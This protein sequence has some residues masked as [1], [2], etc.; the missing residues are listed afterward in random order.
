MNLKYHIVDEK[1]IAPFVPELR[2]L[3]EQIEY[4]LDDG[5]G[6]FT[7]DH[8]DAYY[9]FFLQQGIKVRFLIITNNN[10]VVGS[11][12]GV[13]KNITFGERDYMGLYAADLK[14]NP[15][16][17]K[18]GIHRKALWHLFI[19]WPLVKD[20]QGWD[21]IYYCAMQRGGQGV[22]TAFKGLHLGKVANAVA[23]MNIYIVDPEKFSKLNFD[24]FPNQVFKQI[25]LSPHR[26]EELLWNDGVKN[27]IS[28]K[29][30]S[31]LPL[32][33]LHTNLLTRMG[34]KSLK[35]AL[36]KIVN[37]TNGLA[38]FAIDRRDEKRILWL[39]DH[40]IQTN[41]RCKIFSFSPFAPNLRKS[42]ILCISTG[43]I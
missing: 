36:E 31:I 40:G 16:F 35:K 3:E 37:R 13:W 27:I 1:G 41:T 6:G 14:L 29:D 43:E 22:N 26:H 18:K 19:R 38:C 15:D 28:T 10:T 24:N 5:S 8:G 39:Q 4:P 17:R 23:E 42:G 20:F 30:D 33:H 2:A 21:F 32:G 11:I 25:N 7:I 9:S 12:T 34:E